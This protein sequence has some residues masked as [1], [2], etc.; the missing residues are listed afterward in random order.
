MATYAS[1][2]PEEKE[3]LADHYLL[4]AQVMIDIYRLAKRAEVVNSRWNDTISAIVGTLDVGEEIPN[5][6]NYAGTDPITKENASSNACARAAGVASAIQP[7]H[8]FCAPT[9]GT[10]ICRHATRSASKSVKCPSST[11]MSRF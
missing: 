1:L 7:S 8:P 2:S 4:E 3:D 11:T 5:P 6:T 9:S 10:T